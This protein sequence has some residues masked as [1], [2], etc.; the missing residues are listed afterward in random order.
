[1][2]FTSGLPHGLK[3]PGGEANAFVA[4]ETMSVN[5]TNLMAVD[6]LLIDL[7]VEGIHR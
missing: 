7:R 6:Q 1:M 3:Y 2:I 4:N 5:A